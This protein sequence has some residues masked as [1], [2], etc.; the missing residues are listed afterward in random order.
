MGENSPPEEYEWMEWVAE[1]S[2]LRQGEPAP[3]PARTKKGKF[4]S[5]LQFINKLFELIK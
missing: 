2:A 3:P 1:A 4:I 5:L